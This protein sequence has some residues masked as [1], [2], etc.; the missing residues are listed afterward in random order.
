MVRHLSEEAPEW[1]ALYAIAYDKPERLIPVD[2]LH[3]LISPDFRSPMGANL[4]AF[5]SRDQ[6]DPQYYSQLIQWIEV[7]QRIGE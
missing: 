7:V 2:S 3:W 4:V 6:L 1:R 5:S